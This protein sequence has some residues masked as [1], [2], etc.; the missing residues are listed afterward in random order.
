MS[1][2][3]RSSTGHPPYH[4]PSS[5]MWFTASTWVLVS[6]WQSISTWSDPM[7]MGPSV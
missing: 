2:P 5:A 4:V 7:P 6:P 3:L 1:G